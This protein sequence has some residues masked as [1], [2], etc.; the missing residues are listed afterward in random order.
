M[1]EERSKGLVHPGVTAKA[2]AR[3]EMAFGLGHQR[4]VGVAG[5]LWKD[6]I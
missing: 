2:G 1:G 4:Q 3:E 6:S 5:G